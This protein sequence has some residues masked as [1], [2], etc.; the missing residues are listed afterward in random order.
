MRDRVLYVEFEGCGYQ[1]LF[2]FTLKDMGS[3]ERVRAVCWSFGFR[4]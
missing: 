2:A 4:V 3:G 1:I